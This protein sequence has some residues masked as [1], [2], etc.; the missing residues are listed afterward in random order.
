MPRFNPRLPG[1]R[2]LGI[3]NLPIVLQRQFQ[4]TPSGGKAT[5]YSEHRIAR[6]I[7][8]QS[9]P[10][11]GKATQSIFVAIVQACFNPRLPGGRRPDRRQSDCFSRVV[12]I[13]AFR[14]EGDNRDLRRPRSVDAFQS[15][16]SGGKATLAGAQRAE[17]TDVSIHAFRGEGDESSSSQPTILLKFQSTP[18]GGKA[19]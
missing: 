6:Q 8:F 2:R 7:K 14:G 10:S 4:S 15:T 17:H 13:H 18:S 12:S 3:D 9:T 11:G 1:G 5:G 19:T 16:P